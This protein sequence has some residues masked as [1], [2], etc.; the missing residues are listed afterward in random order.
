MQGIYVLD[1]P[2]HQVFITYAGS[3]GEAR[4]IA[5]QTL[6]SALELPSA[7]EQSFHFYPVKSDETT[8]EA[9]ARVMESYAS[10]CTYIV[11]MR[12]PTQIATGTW[13]PSLSRLRN[14]PSFGSLSCSTQS[15]TF[16]MSPP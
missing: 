12:D 9:E 10:T 16:S 3:L 8:L 5:Y 4:I 1:M 2:L 6:S 7:N 14:L 15:P 11:H 13:T